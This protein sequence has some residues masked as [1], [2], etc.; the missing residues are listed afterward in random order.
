MKNTK[1]ITMAEPKTLED[2]YF[3]RIEKCDVTDH[4]IISVD[5]LPYS[6]AT[7]EIRIDNKEDLHFLGEY[8]KDKGRD[9]QPLFQIDGKIF[10]SL[11][12]SSDAINKHMET[13][14]EKYDLLTLLKSHDAA[15]LCVSFPEKD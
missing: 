1:S 14:L 4:A 6:E 3:K 5:R 9:L 7:H 11:F 8:S 2:C 13:F 15:L 10:L 12:F